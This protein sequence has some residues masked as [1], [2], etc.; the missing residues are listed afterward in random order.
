M[1]LSPDLVLF[2][3]RWRAKAQL[4]RGAEVA[5]WFDKFFS[6]WVLF[7][8]LYTEVAWRTGNAGMADSVA[9]QDNL[10]QYLGGR[11]FIE[12]FEANPAALAAV[13]D[14]Q[15]FLT[16]HVYY[17]KLDRATG[18]RQP[19]ED[20][21]LLRDFQSNGSN[22][23]GKAILEA[24][25]SVRCNLFHGHKGFDPGQVDLLRPMTVILE[26]VIDITFHH[27]QSRP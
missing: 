19:A 15:T 16:G 20:E 12:A 18:A 17:F 7:N 4:Y 24:L 2:C 9:G 8:A 6:L 27:L 1:A 13:A 21:R 23:Q 10:L 5:D 22:G 11:A 14:I 3:D 25:Y 26:T